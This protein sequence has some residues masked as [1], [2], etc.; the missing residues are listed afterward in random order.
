VTG[1]RVLRLPRVVVA[2]SLG[3]AA[4]VVVGV[5][6]V[7]T[8]GLH[9]ERAVLAGVV[10]TTAWAASALLVPHRAGPLRWPA[11]PVPEHVSGWHLLA[12]RAAGL[13]RDDAERTTTGRTPT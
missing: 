12:L 4:G 9:V 13:R 5:V 8:A 1:L 2:V 10:T 6:L 3:V 11:P 7:V